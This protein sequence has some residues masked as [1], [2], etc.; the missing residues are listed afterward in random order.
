MNKSYIFIGSLALLVAFGFGYFFAPNK[1][2]EVEKIVEVVKVEHS[3]TVIRE[4]PDGTKETTIVVDTDTRTDTI[5]NTREETISKSK[6]NL[7]VLIG[8][9]NYGISAL[10][11]FLGPLTFGGFAI[12]SKTFND[13]KY[14]VSIGIN[15]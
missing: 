11:T 10:H 4:K 6:T 15:L 14:G 13:L 5:E 2:K 7:S 9:E 3:T 8:T 12:S 1:I